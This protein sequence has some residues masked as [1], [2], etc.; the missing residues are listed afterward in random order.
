MY[1]G[2]GSSTLTTSLYEDE[3]HIF[4]PKSKTLIP[5]FPKGKKCRQGSAN[6]L[7]AFVFV[8]MR[9]AHL[10]VELVSQFYLIMMLW[11]N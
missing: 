7:H 8:E 1:L 6:F 3:G 11:A 9:F 10:T 4:H 2:N 5:G